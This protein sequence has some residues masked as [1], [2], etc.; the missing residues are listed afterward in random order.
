MQP[1]LSLNFPQKDQYANA[2]EKGKQIKLC[3]GLGSLLTWKT[4]NSSQLENS[5]TPLQNLLLKRRKECCFMINAMPTKI[6]L[7][8]VSL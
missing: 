4:T 7:F 1:L 5:K 3:C 2:V 8:A 6:Y